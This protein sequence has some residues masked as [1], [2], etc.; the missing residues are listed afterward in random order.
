MKLIEGQYTK[1]IA[2]C[3]EHMDKEP[4]I[5]E[6]QYVPTDEMFRELNRFIW[7]AR[8][9]TEAR[10]SNHYRGS[11][12]VDISAWNREYPNK[13]FDAFLYYLKDHEQELD[14]CFISEYEFS[15]KIIERIGR[16]FDADEP[17]RIGE[18]RGRRR[19]SDR[20]SVV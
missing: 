6:M 5:F 10:F 11:V 9:T 1:A 2:W 12:V 18:L 16:L 8:H 19:T 15:P 14:C 13:Y 7:E 4:F 17:V 20:K 3:M